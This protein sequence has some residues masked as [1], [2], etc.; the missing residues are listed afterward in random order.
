PIPFHFLLILD[1]GITVDMG[2]SPDELLT[3]AIDDRRD[4]KSFFFR[5]NLGVENNVQ[6]DIAKFFFNFNHILFQYGIRKLESLLDGQMTQTFN[7]LL[8]VPRAPL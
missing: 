1:I 3:Q 6:Q 2:M 5:P 4:V 8:A 7:G